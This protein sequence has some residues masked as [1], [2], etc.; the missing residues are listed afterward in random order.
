VRYSHA[1]YQGVDFT[2][3]ELATLLGLEYILSRE[4]TLFGRYRHIAFDSTDEARNYN[5]DEVRVGVRLRR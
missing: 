5:A 3:R 1:D 2:E 4:V